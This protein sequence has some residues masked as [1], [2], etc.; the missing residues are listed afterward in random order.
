MLI[1]FHFQYSKSDAL[2]NEKE[3]NETL[4]IRKLKSEACSKV[5]K[6]T[7]PSQPNPSQQSNISTLSRAF[8]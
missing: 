4:S 7:G 1:F 6:S 2:E 5:G 3:K 8:P